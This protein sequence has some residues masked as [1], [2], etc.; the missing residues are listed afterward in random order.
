M[1][2]LGTVL[3]SG[4][5]IPDDVVRLRG[6]PCRGMWRRITGGR[7]ENQQTG[8]VVPTV[9]AMWAAI[10]GTAKVVETKATRYRV[11]DEVSDLATEPAR[12]YIVG[13][14]DDHGRPTR[15]WAHL[16]DTEPTGWAD[17]EGVWWTWD[18]LAAGGV[19]VLYAPAQL[20]TVTA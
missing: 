12:G 5:Y 7:W 14:V 4:Q 6:A 18:E 9:H 11:G 17:T 3:R 1:T 2:P 19:R 10:G 13:T 15:A 8:D 16:D 20:A